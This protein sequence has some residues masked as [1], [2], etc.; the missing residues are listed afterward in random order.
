MSKV[1]PNEM[2]CVIIG[3]SHAG[4]NLAFSLRKEN[5]QG[6]IILFDKDPNLPYHRPPLSKA[7]LKTPDESLSAFYLK[8]SESYKKANIDL[9]LGIEVLSIDRDQKLV[10][11]KDGKAQH[12]D[13]LVLATGARPFIPPIEGIRKAKHVFTIRWAQDSLLLKK[14]LQKKPGSRVVIIGAGYIGLETAAALCELGAKVLVLERDNR[15][16]ARVTTPQLSGFFQGLHTQHGVQ[17]FPNKNVV[18][19][20]TSGAVD[21]VLCKDGS[22]YEADLIIVGVGVQVNKELAEAAGIAVEDGILVD[23]TTQTN[24][25]DIYA[26]G[27]CTLHFN[28]HYQRKIRLESVQNAVDQAKVSAANICGQ[29]ISY[30]AI[31][32]FWSDQ[33]DVK[34]QMVGLSNGYDQ[35]ILRKE[36]DKER[37]FSIWY[38]KAGQLVAVDAVNH[39]KAYVL[40][41]KFIKSG[42]K[43]SLTNLADPEQVLHPSNLIDST[44]QNV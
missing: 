34:L 7:L 21:R 14:Q 32:W 17:I 38:F 27:D 12:Y 28:P 16:L 8:P 3:A 19:I 29:A 41:T 25:P 1:H 40:G 9:Q 44:D 42:Q 20:D 39:P 24:I 13:K 6:R 37:C 18:S 36:L 35:A 23:S 11:L 31:P 5:W 22:T 10:R 4:V 30:D 15:V 26:V 43:I 33:Y 2:T